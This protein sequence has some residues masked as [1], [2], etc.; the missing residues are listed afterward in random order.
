MRSH[1]ETLGRVQDLNYHVT[2]IWIND[3]KYAYD[4]TA[5]RFGADYRLTD[6]GKSL[7]PSA[8]LNKPA[9]PFRLVSMNKNIISA[10]TLKGKVVLLDF[11]E[12]WCGPCFKSVPKIQA[13]SEKYKAK[14][15]QV[16]GV[17]FEKDQLGAMKKMMEK[18]KVN[19]TVLI[20]DEKTR[21]DYEVVAIP[22]Y[23]IINR[24]GIVSYSHAGFSADIE[25]EI[26]K[27]IG[28]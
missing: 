23:I 20:G 18:F 17:S 22:R 24:K 16:Y 11:L 2:D 3:E 14:G 15:L 12:V 4:F 7:Q 8:L 25:K 5:Q 1:Q 21:K 10:D 27:T 13:L 9:P 19:F 6:Y 28:E 26:V